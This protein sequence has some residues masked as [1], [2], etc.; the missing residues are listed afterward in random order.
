MTLCPTQRDRPTPVVGDR[1]DRPLDAHR[2]GELAQIVDSSRQPTNPSA[3]LGEAH[4]ELVDGDHA[5]T[6]GRRAHEIPE[7]VR[8][9][10]IA[11]HAQHCEVCFVNL[12]VEHMPRATDG[13]RNG[14]VDQPRP[15]WIETVEADG[16]G[17]RGRSTRRA[18]H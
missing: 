18:H 16:R 9:R 2:V 17:A 7:Q 3:A 1:D 10:R 6:V 13:V 15:R 11:V 8:P 5:H 12:V 14:H 4:V